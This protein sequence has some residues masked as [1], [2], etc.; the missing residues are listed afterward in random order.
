MNVICTTLEIYPVQPF[1]YCLNCEKD[2]LHTICKI[3]MLETGEIRVCPVCCACG[4]PEGELSAF[5]GHD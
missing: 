2:W 3:K 4:A 1:A 5:E